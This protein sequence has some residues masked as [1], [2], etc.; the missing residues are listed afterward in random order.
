MVLIDVMHRGGIEVRV[1]Y[2]ED[3]LQDS[4]VLGVN[5]ISIQSDTSIKNAICDDFDMM[6]SQEAGRVPVLW[7]KMHVSSH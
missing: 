5:G 1:V 6:F 7:Q 4:L 3:E 2:V